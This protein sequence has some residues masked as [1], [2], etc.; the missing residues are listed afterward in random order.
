MCF[1]PYGYTKAKI[2]T[3]TTPK[4]HI[5]FFCAWKHLKGNDVL[6]IYIYIDVD[7]KKPWLLTQKHE[8]VSYQRQSSESEG[9]FSVFC[10]APHSRWSALLSK[11]NIA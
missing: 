2:P 10:A 7:R 1:V 3:I 4:T 5:V 11:G 9:V 6:D 8:A